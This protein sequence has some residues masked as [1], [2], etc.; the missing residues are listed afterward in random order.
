MEGTR[1]DESEES[2]ERN[3]SVV[4]GHGGVGEEEGRWQAE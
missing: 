4:G 2:D 3:P 1:N